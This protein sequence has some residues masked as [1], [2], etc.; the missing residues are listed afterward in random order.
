LVAEEEGGVI[1]YAGTTRFRTKTAYD[2]TVEATIY[3]APESIGKGVGNQLYSVLFKTVAKE[4]I[5]RIVAGY[6]LPNPG[7]EALHRRFGLR[8]LVC[9]TRMAGSLAAIGTWPGPNEQ[10]IS[11]EDRAWIALLGFANSRVN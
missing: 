6:T 5:H 11:T 8:P 7:S 9:F 10:C 1:G 3:C 2:T 4:D